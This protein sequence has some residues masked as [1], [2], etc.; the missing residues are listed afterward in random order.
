RLNIHTGDEI[1]N[2]YHALLKTTQDVMDYFDKLRRARRQVAEMDNDLVCIPLE[3]P[4][5]QDIVL[6]W[7]KSGSLYSDSENFI[8]FAKHFKYE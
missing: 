8:Q 2:L 6:I 3:Q 5:I 1:E 7:K 4:I